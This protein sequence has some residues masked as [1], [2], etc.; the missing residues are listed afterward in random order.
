[1]VEFSPIQAIY[2]EPLVLPPIENAR[3]GIQT[4]ARDTATKAVNPRP[5][6]K[7]GIM[8]TCVA[9]VSLTI[10]VS[11]LG[12]AGKFLSKKP[13]PL[14]LRLASRAYRPIYVCIT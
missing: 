14:V 5:D 10:R 8:F 1:M 7:T 13:N 3:F 2:R 6:T 9:I 4:E 12:I 11:E